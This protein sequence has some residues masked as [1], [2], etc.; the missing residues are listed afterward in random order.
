[1]PRR[2]T[3]IT[4]LLAAAVLAGAGAAVLVA[5][6]DGAP[7]EKE[8]L[9]SIGKALATTPLP[10]VGLGEGSPPPPAS[11][12]AGW[13][14]DFGKHSVPFTEIQSGGPPKDGIPAIDAP[15]F[16]AVAD[17]RFLRD[18]EPVIALDLNGEVRAYP[19]QILI[20]HE[21][22]NDE[23]G[24]T[25]LAVT[26]CPLCNTAIVFDRRIGGRVLDFGTTGNLRNSDLVMYDRQTESWWQQFGGEGIVGALT[27]TKLKQL[28]ARIVSWAQFR[29]EN[30]DGKVLSRQTGY[31]RSYGNNPYGGYDDASSPPFFAA[32]NA[33]DDRL[34]PKER[35]V[36]L[37]DKGQAV[38]VPFSLLRKRRQVTVELGAR[39]LD[40]RWTPG[41]ASA[42]GDS[43]IANGAD[44]GSAQV[45]EN[46]KAVPFDEPFWF[47]VA[48]FR[49]DARIVR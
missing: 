6:R 27:G 26:F 23:I 5:T 18:R 7:S 22:V 3:L 15:Q 19:I 42:L 48:A 37:E 24:G 14:T 29:R 45:L 17:V 9:D 34:P 28:P 36:Y 39:R 8:V 44:V 41:V 38:V 10:N 49:P 2:R 20:W 25:P 40:V 46:G 43:T 11:L 31:Q 12:T 1:M 21:I 30:P 4:L 35:V 16:V 32:A 13:N 47:S 33:G